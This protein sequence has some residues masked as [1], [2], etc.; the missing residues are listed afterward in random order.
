MNKE[1]RLLILGNFEH[2][3]LIQF[4]KKLKEYNPN[5]HLFF[6]GYKREE[7]DADRSFLECY[8]EYYLFDINH[9]EGASVT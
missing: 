7:Y 5:A 1:Y 9:Y 6:W 8:D 4:V 2:V 3:Y